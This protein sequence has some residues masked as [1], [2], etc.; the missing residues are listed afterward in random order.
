M[1]NAAAAFEAAADLPTLLLDEL[2]TWHNTL[3]HIGFKSSRTPYNIDCNDALQP[4]VLCTKQQTTC[5][6]TALH[7]KSCLI[8]NGQYCSPTASHSYHDSASEGVLTIGDI[9]PVN[10]ISTV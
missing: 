7:Y 2:L 1:A 4:T 8:T 6:C 3:G 9:T 5:S 10:K